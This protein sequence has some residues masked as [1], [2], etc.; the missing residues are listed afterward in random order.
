MIYSEKFKFMFLA[1][2]KTGTTFVE[3]ILVDLCKGLSDHTLTTPSPHL[4][5]QVGKYKKHDE[6]KKVSSLD[7]AN[8]F[9]FAFTRNPYDR[10]VSWYSYLTQKR[11]DPTDR[12]EHINAYGEQFLSGDFTDFVKCAPPWVT[13]SSLDWVVDEKNNRRVDFVGR[14]ENFDNDLEYIL[15]R[16]FRSELTFVDFMR[17]CKIDEWVYNSSKHKKYTDYYTPETKK[18]IQ[19]KCAAELDYFKYEL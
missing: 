4:S 10:V 14:Y 1:V 11:N 13:Q 12:Q 5:N 17:L 7:F 2:P 8:K 6:L 16:I 18:I 9:T 19:N 15:K 3:R